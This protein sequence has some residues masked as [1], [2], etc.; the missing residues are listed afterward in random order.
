MTIVLAMI[1]VAS[2]LF[3]TLAVRWT[4]AADSL[5]ILIFIL[6]YLFA[7]TRRLFDLPVWGGALAVVLFFPYA[8]VT[9]N[10][11]GMVFGPM[12]GSTPYAAVALLILIYALAT[13]GP[14]RTGL[15][16]GAGLLALS[17]FFRSVD[18]SVCAD[19]PLGTHFLW[20]ILNG[21]M[22]G[23]MVIVLRCLGTPPLAASRPES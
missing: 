21:V 10:I 15:A 18:A 16:I 23:H 4:G 14:A 8:I 12:N 13:S 2:G 5:S 20:H 22:L 3:H 11:A 9:A 19:F 17:I 1:G 6:I 7:A